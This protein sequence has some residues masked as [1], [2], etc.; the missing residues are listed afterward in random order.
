MGSNKNNRDNQNNN[1]DEYDERGGCGCTVTCG[2]SVSG[3]SSHK[4]ERSKDEKCKSYSFVTKN[5]FDV[6]IAKQL[7]EDEYLVLLTGNHHSVSDY[8]HDKLPDWVGM[9]ERP[10]RIYKTV[11]TEELVDLWQ[12]DHRSK[13]DPCYRKKSFDV[14]HPN[15]FINYYLTNG[16]NRSQVVEIKD[17]TVDCSQGDPTLILKVKILNK[18]DDRLDLDG[19][20]PRMFR[21]SL[22]IDH[23]GK[24]HADKHRS[25]KH[26]SDKHHKERDT[27]VQAP[28]SI[29]T[30]PVNFGD[31]S[32]GPVD[33][34]HGPTMS[35][36]SKMM[37]PTTTTTQSNQQTS[38][39][40]QAQQMG[41]GK[42]DKEKKKKKHEKCKGLK[43]KK[44]K[45]C[46]KKHHKNR[47]DHDDH[48]DHHDHHDHQDQD[49]HDDKKKSQN[50]KH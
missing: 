11:T 35:D 49:D 43:G 19:L 9:G 50:S 31:Y 14:C 10:C 37:G 42:K 24:I 45:K 16:T 18:G 22:V 48:D 27:I 23:Y 17:A 2:C 46:L 20:Y 38:Q 41:E 15:G 6:G 5:P 21:V 4:K 26:H 32:H 44:K 29:V 39:Q 3:H 34:S 33:Q 47:G 36:S 12:L 7:D 8:D 30:G 13:H 40:Q 25:D 1:D 28:P